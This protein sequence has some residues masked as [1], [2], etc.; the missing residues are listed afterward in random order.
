VGLVIA[1]ARAE[2]S[3]PAAAAVG[4]LGNMVSFE[5][6]ALFVSIDPVLNRSQPMI[7]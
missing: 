2:R 5:E 7:R 3:N 6:A 1:S 4:F